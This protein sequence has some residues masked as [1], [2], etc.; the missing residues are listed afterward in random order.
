VEAQSYCFS[1]ANLITKNNDVQILYKQRH[2]NVNKKT[3]SFSVSF[4]KMARV[5]N[6][7]SGPARRTRDTD[8]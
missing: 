7:R 4:H 6:L 5:P 8:D 2:K 1:K 3:V